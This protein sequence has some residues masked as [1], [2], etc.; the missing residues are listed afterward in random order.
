MG[1]G[2]MKGHSNNLG[3]RYKMSH[4]FEM[5]SEFCNDAVFIYDVPTFVPLNLEYVELYGTTTIF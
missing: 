5:I 1:S 3:V 2:D 4:N